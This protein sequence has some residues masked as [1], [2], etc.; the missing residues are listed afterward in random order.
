MYPINDSSDEPIDFEKYLAICYIYG[1]D[2]KNKFIYNLLERYWNA[3]LTQ[4][5]NIIEKECIN[6]SWNTIYMIENKFN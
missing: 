3:L 2:I 1:Y 6:L 4:D 5:T